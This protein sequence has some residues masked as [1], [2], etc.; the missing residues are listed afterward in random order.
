MAA[1]TLYPRY[2]NRTTFASG[3]KHEL[4]AIFEH[5]YRRVKVKKFATRRKTLEWFSNYFLFYLVNFLPEDL[6]KSVTPY[7]YANPSV[8]QICNLI[9]NITTA[10]IQRTGSSSGRNI[11]TSQRLHDTHANFE[12]YFPSNEQG[13]SDF[14]YGTFLVRR[15]ANFGADKS[16]IAE[17]DPNRSINASF[18]LWTRPMFE[19]RMM[20][21]IRAG[22]HAP[23][24]GSLE[25]SGKSSRSSSS[26]SRR[27]EN[28]RENRKKHSDDTKKTSAAAAAGG[29]VVE[30][31]FSFF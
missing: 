4:D 28:Q 17:H 26:S 22:R 9:V 6:L 1:A 12:Q 20:A 15:I 13:L 2:N 3:V 23:R 25:G 7:N 21:K 19:T 16:H 29:G 31:L 30:Y 27:S 11:T 10:I 5:F 8:D 18:G 14:K 24:S